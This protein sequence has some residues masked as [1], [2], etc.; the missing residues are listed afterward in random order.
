MEKEASK[1]NQNMCQVKNAQPLVTNHKELRKGLNKT[2]V[3]NR[4]AG[5][6]R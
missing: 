1:D 2:M 4:E 6:M 3:N 5:R